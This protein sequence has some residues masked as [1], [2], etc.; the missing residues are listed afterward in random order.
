MAAMQLKT[1]SLIVVVLSVAWPSQALT[2]H[3]YIAAEEQLWDYA[4]SGVD[5]VES[6]SIPSTWAKRTKF[7]K[8]RY[9]E[10]TDDTFTKP[11]PQPEWLGILGPIIRAE[12]GDTVI[13][14]FLNRSQRPA[15]IHPHGLRYDKENEGSFY[16]PSTRGGLVPPNA[17]YTYRWFADAGSGPGSGQLSSMVWWYHSHAN[18]SSDIN[19]GLMGPI[20]VTAKGNARPDGSPRDVD[21]EFVAA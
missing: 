8:V 19:A 5:L 6:R 1:A 18:S 17:R 15:G 11:K 4:P 13:V 10:Y 14:D 16:L 12:V 3:Y 7:P 2:R 20:I 9:I 21:R